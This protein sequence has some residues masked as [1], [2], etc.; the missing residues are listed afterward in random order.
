MS[1]GI[2]RRERLAGIAG[3]ALVG[4]GSD[5][6]VAAGG[7]VTAGAARAELPVPATGTAARRTLGRTGAEVE[8]FSLGGE[9]ILRT[10]GRHDDAVPVVAA[11]LRHGVKYCDTAPAYAQSQEYYGAAF[12]ASPG[13]RDRLFLASK[14][15]ARDRDGA[16]RLLDDS[17]RKLG[18]DHLDLWQMHDLRDPEELDVLFGRGGA[19]QAA[20]AAKADGRI[21]FVGLTGH[22][23]PE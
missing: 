23:H 16:L 4:C 18:T 14:T 2:T 11:A 1:D 6:R 13:A 7:R 19:I 22:H 8:A 5:E 12:R 3:A 17:L 15:H 20:E 21:R 10:V 9:G